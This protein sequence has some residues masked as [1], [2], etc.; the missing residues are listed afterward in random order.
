MWNISP[1]SK[2]QLFNGKISPKF[3]LGHSSLSDICAIDAYIFW[4]VLCLPL[5][6]SFC[7]ERLLILLKRTWFRHFSF[8]FGRLGHFAI[9]LSSDLHLKHLRGVRSL[10]LLS[11]SP[12]ARYF[13][14]YF[15]IFLKIN[16]A[17]W[18]APKK[19]CILYGQD[20]LSHYFSHNRS[21][22]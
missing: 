15:L 9:G 7:P 20:F 19:K 17:E 8:S 6:H 22:C 16:S 3:R 4:S 11:E 21:C 18:L 13:S 5:L 2:Y 10:R 1:E 14:F 12:P